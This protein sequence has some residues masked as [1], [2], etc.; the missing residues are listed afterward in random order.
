MMRRLAMWMI[1]VYWVT[2]SPIIGQACRF[3]PTCSRYTYACVERFGALRGSW[4]GAKRIARCHPFHPGGF[5][6]PPG[7]EPHL[8]PPPSEQSHG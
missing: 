3:H 7:L 2:L 6:P 5:D 8:E 4:L 1:R